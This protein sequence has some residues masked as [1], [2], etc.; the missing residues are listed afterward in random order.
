MRSVTLM[1][2]EDAK[3]FSKEERE[4]LL[5]KYPAHERD[6]RGKGIPMLGGG[7]IYAPLLDEHVVCRAMRDVPEHWPVIGG[8]DFGFGH[9]TAAVRV[10]WDRDV[11]VSY[12]TNVYR[13]KEQT[14]VVHAS[15]LKRWG[16]IPWAWPHDGEHATS[17]GGGVDLA[18]QYRK[19]GLDMLPE[20]AKYEKLS[21]KSGQSPP[22]GS[23]EAGLMDLYDRMQAG[24]L[25]VF[26]HCWEWFEEFRLYH[27]KDGRVVKQFDDLMDATRYAHMMLRYSRVVGPVA[28]RKGRRRMISGWM[29]G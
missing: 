29:G 23:V 27:R 21:R 5:Q 4:A 10:A 6:V 7:R 18:T 26:E 22:R 2:L 28:K 11:D 24:R 17:S 12:I 9:P 25:K 13:V 8:I 15:A 1:T 20:R 14:P 16:N 19:E 3:H